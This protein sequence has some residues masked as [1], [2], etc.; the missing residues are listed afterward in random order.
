M[1][2]TEANKILVNSL[3]FKTFEVQSWRTFKPETAKKD[4]IE[5][6]KKIGSNIIYKNNGEDFLCLD[7][8]SEI[9]VAKVAHPIHDGPFPLSGSGKCE[10]E[11]VPYCPKCEE[12]PSYSGMLINVEF[13]I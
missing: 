1:E 5:Y 9:I 13:Q 12:K 8:N 7:C 2:R 11:Q 10:Y 4:E 6:H 3:E